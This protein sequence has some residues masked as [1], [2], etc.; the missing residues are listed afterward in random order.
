MVMKLDKDTYRLPEFLQRVDQGCDITE[1]RPAIGDAHAQHVTATE[2]RAGY[3]CRLR[4]D[5]APCDLPGI[6]QAVRRIDAEDTDR[7]IVHH[8]PA[9]CGQRLPEM[10]S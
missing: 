10:G 2:G 4:G 3:P 9:A 8:A 5:D 7:R 1:R 6:R